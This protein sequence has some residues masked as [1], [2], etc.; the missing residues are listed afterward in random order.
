M[1]YT[2]SPLPAPDRRPPTGD[3]KDPHSSSLTLSTMSSLPVS[4]MTVAE[5]SGLFRSRLRSSVWD[6]L[7]SLARCVAWRIAASAA[8]R[9]ATC[10]RHHLGLGFSGPVWADVLPA[11]PSCESCFPCFLLSHFSVPAPCTLSLACWASIANFCFE[12]LQ[13]VLGLGGPTLGLL[14]LVPL[15]VEAQIL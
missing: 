5:L 8:M 4:G 3:R 10:C 14:D 9:A 7:V 6:L 12:L 13:I 11:G 2:S 15:E 1:M